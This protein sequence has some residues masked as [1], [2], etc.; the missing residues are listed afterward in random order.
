MSIIIYIDTHG[1]TW[2][3][4]RKSTHQPAYIPTPTTMGMIPTVGMG[5]GKPSDTHGYT[6]A[7]PYLLADKDGMRDTLKFMA[8][9]H[10]LQTISGEGLNLQRAETEHNHP[11]GST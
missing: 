2:Y 5:M 10:R 11:P 1:N 9:T 4:H 6:H 7:T 3:T 8:A